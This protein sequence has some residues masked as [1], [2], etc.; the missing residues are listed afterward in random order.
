MFVGGSVQHLPE[1]C[2]I[3][4]HRLQ[5]T[6]EK[7]SLD[8]PSAFAT[9]ILPS[10]LYLGSYDNASCAEPLKAQ[11]I[12]RILN[13]VPTYK[14]S[15]TYKTMK[16]EQSLPFDDCYDFI[17][18]SSRKCMDTGALHVWAEQVSSNCNFLFDAI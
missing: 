10:F 7:S 11:G 6:G 13:M 2:S 12:S 5:D 15:F 9:E 14:N 3:Y 16:G 17:E 1:V 4:R 18:Q 8:T